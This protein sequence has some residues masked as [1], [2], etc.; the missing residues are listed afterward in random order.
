M[1]QRSSAD[2]DFVATAPRL[3]SAASLHLCQL[4]EQ[5]TFGLLGVIY[6]PQVYLYGLPSQ[7]GT[8]N[9]KIHNSLLE[10][11]CF[12]LVLYHA[13]RFNKYFD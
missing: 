7:A 9:F 1:G 2:L 11:D 8:W 5:T 13:R 12:I 10:A 6:E 3:L 4:V